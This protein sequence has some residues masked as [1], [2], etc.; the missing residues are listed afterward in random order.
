MSLLD[1]VANAL[2]EWILYRLIKWIERHRLL[3]ATIATL[4]AAALFFLLQ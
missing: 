1:F 4:I 2:L 3:A